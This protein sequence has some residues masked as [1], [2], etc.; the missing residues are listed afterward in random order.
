MERIDGGGGLRIRRE[1]R[2]H[3]LLYADRA[4]Q[5]PPGDPASDKV[6]VVLE[7]SDASP[8]DGLLLELLPRRARGQATAFGESVR[9]Y[10]RKRG[11]RFEPGPWRYSGGWL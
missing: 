4:D 7:G 2:L 8:G 5:L 1:G 9:E 11:I 10:F 6:Y 3:E